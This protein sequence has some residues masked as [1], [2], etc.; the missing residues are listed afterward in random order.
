[1]RHLQLLWR[2]PLYAENAVLLSWRVL[3]QV[4]I[5]VII[6]SMTDI[7]MITNNITLKVTLMTFFGIWLE[8]GFIFWEAEVLNN[9]TCEA[10]VCKALLSINIF[11]KYYRLKIILNWISGV[12][13]YLRR[14]AQQNRE[15]RPCRR[16]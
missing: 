12:Q 15:R 4:Q 7:N 2:N 8:F 16:F 3:I 11:I 13:H 10:Y 1:M 9:K 5:E 14:L 6:I